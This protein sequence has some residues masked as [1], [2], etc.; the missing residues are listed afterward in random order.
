[1]RD[2]PADRGLRL[3]LACDCDPD[4][5]LYGGPGYDSREPALWRGVWE[6]IPRLIAALDLIEAEAGARINL[7]WCLRSD[8]QM[9]E[10]HGHPAWPSLEYRDLWR[11]L[12]ERGD[13]IAWHPHLWRWNGHA[14]CWYQET[15]DED[16][17]ARCLRE[18]YAALSEALGHP[19]TACRMGWEYHSNLTMRIVD[20]LGILVDITAVPGFRCQGMS[21]R[22]SIFH[23]YN[24]W[25]TTPDRPYHPSAADYRRPARPGEAALGLVEIPVWT[26]VGWHWRVLGAA[27]ASA[28]HLARGRVGRALR[29]EPTLRMPAFTVTPRVFAGAFAAARRG[30]ASGLTVTAF[31]CDELLPAPGLRGRTF[32]L[33]QAAANARFIAGHMTAITAT[34]AG[35]GVAPTP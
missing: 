1:M 14:R 29:P 22:G 26:R 34:Q 9:A 27:R 30:R 16:W 24:D 18:G 2:G 20:S 8:L 28:G 6:G 12:E 21:D 35:R 3:I 13:E 31:H 25:R 23:R 10:L 33:E 19:V 32:G 4:R 15:E 7:T 5:V 11:R 17:I